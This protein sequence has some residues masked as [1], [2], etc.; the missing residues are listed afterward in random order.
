MRGISLFLS[1]LWL[2]CG[3][4]YSNDLNVEL[5]A[6]RDRDTE[7]LER[8]LAGE[9]VFEEVKSINRKFKEEFRTVQLFQTLDEKNPMLA[10]RC[11]R[12]VRDILLDG[13]RAERVLFKKYAGDLIGYLQNEIDRQAQMQTVMESIKTQSRINAFMR[14]F[15]CCKLQ[16][17]GSKLA[18]LAHEEGDKMT[19][20]TLNRVVPKIHLILGW[21][22]PDRS[23]F[24]LFGLLKAR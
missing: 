22:E 7:R 18:L 19:E 23:L 15:T 5:K 21:E 3:A 17:L 2:A 16:T 12:H 8:G 1:C 13:N 14:C 20:E 9:P 4:A 24:P 6:R 11:F 10:R